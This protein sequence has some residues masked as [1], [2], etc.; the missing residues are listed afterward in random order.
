VINNSFHEMGVGR[1]F[2]ISCLDQR[3]GGENYP[4]HPSSSGRR[5]KKVEGELFYLLV[6]S[7][8]EPLSR[9][10]PR[11]ERGRKEGQP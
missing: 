7:R 2:E 1:Y 11:W 9:H 4:D 3:P 8:A 10:L 6:A 5:G